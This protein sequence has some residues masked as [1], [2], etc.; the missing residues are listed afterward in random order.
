MKRAA[1]LICSALLL[2]GC[3][4]PHQRGHVTL[5]KEA[6]RSSEVAAVLERYREVRNTAISLLDP[7]PLS[8][9]ESG[10]VLNID[11][12]SFQVSQ[13]LA[14]K[15]KQDNST[16]DLTSVMTPRFTA[17]PLWFVAVTR[18]TALGVNRVQVF[19]RDSAVDPWLLVASPET[20]STT[21]LPDLRSV[22][23]TVVTVKPGDD[24]GMSMSPQTA[25]A[26]YAKALADPTS[27]DASKVVEDSF[28]KQMRSAAAKNAA[29][30][31]VKFSQSWA[32]KKVHYV[33]RTSDGGALAF[34]TLIRRDTYKVTSGLTI[35][36]P[37]G[38][39]QEAFLSAGI[40]GSGTLN[41][42]HQVLLYIPGSGGKPRA[43]GQYGGVIGAEGN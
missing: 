40:S 28:I 41:Y 20:V 6:A 33:L 23:G 22:G 42:D 2:A 25:A 8:I 38:T 21:S 35:S 10:S 34:V 32:S 30:K 26:S 36:W 4:T 15:Q 13:L 9:V 39:P 11:S 17:Y 3:A 43:I 14:R 7:K 19:Q 5:S 12:G 29:L 18:D 1:L 24:V 16:V 31:G 37:K 27:A